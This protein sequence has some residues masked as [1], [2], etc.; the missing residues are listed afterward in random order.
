MIQRGHG[1]IPWVI[2]GLIAMFL[3]YWVYFAINLESI[4]VRNYRECVRLG[5][6][7]F[8]DIGSYPL[9]SNGHHAEEEAVER[10]RRSVRAFSPL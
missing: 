1:P 4:P 2:G 9:L 3:G 8:K 5:V 7:Y 6:E 10:C